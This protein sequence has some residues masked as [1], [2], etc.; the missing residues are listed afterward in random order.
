M[1]IF[2]LLVSLISFKTYANSTQP[3]KPFLTDYCTAYPEGTR[4]QPD[5]WK[6]CCIEHDLYFWAGGSRDD[7]KETDLRLKTCVEATGEVEI[8]RLI[9]AAVTIGGASPIRFKTKEWG[10]A[11]EGRERYLS[12]SVDET[13]M[14][15]NQLD[16]QETEL[17]SE[18]KNNFYEQLNSRLDLK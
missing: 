15:M 1:N 18:M 9:Y 17:T 11:F 5:L 7:R 3:L 14:V 8:A 12:L 16:Q 6:H 13:T 4:D 10:H 2:I